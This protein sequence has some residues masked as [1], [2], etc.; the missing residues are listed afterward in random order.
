MCK[1]F[2]E[3][4]RVD[5]IG[6]YSVKLQ[7]VLIAL[8]FFNLL[9]LLAGV[10]SWF[11]ALIEI[12][13]L[14]V[15]FHG[16]HKRKHRP[17]RA[18]VCVNITFMILGLIFMLGAL[19]VYNTNSDVMYEDEPVMEI[20]PSQNNT[21]MQNINT[22]LMDLHPANNASNSDN[23][24]IPSLDIP[25][26]SSYDSVSGAYV[27]LY[28]LFAIA[29]ILVLV[30]KFMSIVMAAR[31]AR[32]ICAY[33][34]LHLSHPTPSPSSKAEEVSPSPSYFPMQPVPQQPNQPMYPQPM[35]VPVVINGQPN[36]QPQQFVYPSPYFVPQSMYTPYAPTQ[37]NDKN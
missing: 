24:T 1:R 25:S 14:W 27:T 35:Y 19:M 20:N 8:A 5:E 21:E 28:I 12:I 34:C 13:L 29:Q 4:Q 32:M 23:S 37:S 16:A 7:K 10:N 9:G 11:G 6:F 26:S 31:L 18:Y 17:L 22:P 33:N 2:F 30:L 3:N 36:G 15:A